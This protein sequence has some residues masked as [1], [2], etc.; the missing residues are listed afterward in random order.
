MAIGY[1]HTLYCDRHGCRTKQ[2]VEGTRDAA[3][4]RRLARM[5]HGWQCDDAGDFCANDRAARA[6]RDS[7]GATQ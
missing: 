2:T 6:T 4:A 7:K 3:H 1:A 5:R